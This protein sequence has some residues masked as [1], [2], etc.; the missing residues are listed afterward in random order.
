[1]HELVGRHWDEGLKWREHEQLKIIQSSTQIFTTNRVHNARNPQHCSNWPI[2]RHS[3]PHLD[4]KLLRIVS[5][6]QWSR[7]RRRNKNCEHNSLTKHFH[8][9]PHRPN[10]WV[11]FL[12][13]VRVIQFRFSPRSLS[14]SIS[15]LPMWLSSSPD[16]RNCRWGGKKHIK[17]S[18]IISIWDFLNRPPA[19]QAFFFADRPSTV[20]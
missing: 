20:Q 10:F 17:K 15:T 7:R 2:N 16:C 1:M 12:L 19:L 4:E 18:Y 8:F 11:L 13:L 9:F 5:Q 14:R 6:H 3:F